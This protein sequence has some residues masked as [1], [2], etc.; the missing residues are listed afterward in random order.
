MYLQQLKISISIFNQFER[1][2][3]EQGLA[4]LAYR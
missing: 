3:F 4:K 2:K 1:G